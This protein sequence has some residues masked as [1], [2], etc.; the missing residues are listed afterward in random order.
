MHGLECTCCSESFIRSAH[1]LA[2][3]VILSMI[4]LDRRH[5]HGGGRS[6]G[7]SDREETI[8]KYKGNFWPS[9]A[10]RRSTRTACS[11]SSAA[12]P[13][14]KSSEAGRP[15]QGDHRWGACASWG[16]VQAARPIPPGNPGAQGD[17]RQADHQG[18]GLPADRRSD[19]RRHLYGDLRPHSRA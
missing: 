8:Q 5:A 10:I 12:A 18:A 13:S 15:P 3:D 7:R 9:K 14:S 11:A 1:P 6:S 19:D 2:K 17:C 16:C 4:S